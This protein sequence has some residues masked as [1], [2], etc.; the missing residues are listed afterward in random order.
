MGRLALLFA[1]A[2]CAVRPGEA[3]RARTRT[4]A[5]FTAAAASAAGTIARRIVVDGATT[6]DAAIALL[7]LGAT[8]PTSA[9]FYS[10][11]HRL[12]QEGALGPAT[13]NWNDLARVALE[14]RFPD[15]GLADRL[16]ALA[17]PTLPRKRLPD[18]PPRP[19][20]VPTPASPA[21]PLFATLHVEAFQADN[22]S[23]MH[24]LVNTATHHREALG[25][26]SIAL[27]EQSAGN[28]KI[29]VLVAVAPA[30]GVYEL[31]AQARRLVAPRITV[32]LAPDA[33]IDDGGAFVTSD[34]RDMHRFRVTFRPEVAPAAVERLRRG[35]M[36]L[37]PTG[38]GAYE[39]S[40]TR[41][42][43]L[44]LAA[45]PEVVRVV[46]IGLR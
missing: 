44:R 41:A 46:R 31:A 36:F 17:V 13:T 28:E 40:A 25:L 9:Q 38:D 33:K 30:E 22:R 4:G 42:V 29:W 39:G 18:Y 21:R 2:T 35:G 24:D 23:T 27:S 37:A 20:L 34:P 11:F 45:E 26:E 5:S 7:K 12:A 10:V 32:K 6:N 16:A 14:A 3:M 15:R 19:L 1:L 8:V 43:L